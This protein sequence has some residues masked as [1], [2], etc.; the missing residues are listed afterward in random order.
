MIG[1]DLASA[2]LIAAM[3]VPGMPLA[4]MVALLFVASVLI[5][6]FS[7]ARS[8]T[9]RDIFPDDDTY[10]RA[11]GVTGTLVRVAI[12][13]GLLGGG[14]ATAALGPRP[15]LL[16]DA[17]TFLL[18]AVVVQRCVRARPAAAVSHAGGHGGGHAGGH[19]GHA[20]LAAARI[21]AGDPVLRTCTLYG[22]L[23]A[24]YAVPFG[25]V[26]PYAAERGGGAWTIGLLLGAPA[27][28]AGA[29][30]W[31][32]TTR[33]P[34][35]AQ[36][37]ILIPGS[38][39]S[40]AALAAMAIDPSVPVAALLWA[41][42]GAG[43]AYQIVVNVRFQQAIPNQRRAAAFAVVSAGL[44]GGQGLAMLAAAA[45]SE[46]IGTAQA[47]AAFGAAGTLLALLLAPAGRRLVTPPQAAA[48]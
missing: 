14:A 44:L 30:T 27:V 46:Q 26:A 19:A 18:S 24:A 16:L 39:L 4:A 32:L 25:V 13:A 8:A 3:I 5:G 17:A 43:G 36:P 41:L 20:G 42:S 34:P 10:P 28:T 38:L 40:C 15:V 23:A 47:I 48:T 2:G 22:W 12:G 31:W 11:V 37:R 1:C 9:I 7:A 6:P 29:V 21:I 33:V 45:L 35:A